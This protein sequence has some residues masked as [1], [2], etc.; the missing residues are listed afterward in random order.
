MKLFLFPSSDQ[1]W[2]QPQR[3]MLLQLGC[4]CIDCLISRH[5]DFRGG[6]IAR[7][8]FGTPERPLIVPFLFL[9]LFSSSAAS[10]FAFVS[11]RLAFPFV[12]VLRTNKGRGSASSTETAGCVDRLG[13]NIFSGHFEAIGLKNFVEGF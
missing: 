13:R 3:R 11:L 4:L 2:G 1:S 8:F 12:L 10:L 7:S 6:V 9:F 5:F